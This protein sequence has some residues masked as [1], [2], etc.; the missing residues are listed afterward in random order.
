[1]SEFKGSANQAPKTLEAIRN[2]SCGWFYNAFQ[3]DFK[4]IPEC[5][6]GYFLSNKTIDIIQREKTLNSFGDTRR[7]L[8][9]GCAPLYIRYWYEISNKDLYYP[10]YNIET[11]PQDSSLKWFVFNSGGNFRKWFGNLDNVVLWQNNGYDIRNNNKSI[12]PSEHLYF[13][14]AITWNKIT[15]SNISFKLQSKGIIPGDASPGFFPYT[16]EY[17]LY[18]LGELNSKVVIPLLKV[19]APTLNAQVGDMANI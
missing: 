5:R 7:G 14:T 3:G 4:R 17:D 1:M 10:I 16:N 6:L 2:P 9:T 19:F 11:R 13:K 12:I 18:I 15:S 8:Q